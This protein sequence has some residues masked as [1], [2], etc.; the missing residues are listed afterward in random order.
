M[1]DEQP[2]LRSLNQIAS[3]NPGRFDVIVV[4]YNHHEYR[5]RCSGRPITIYG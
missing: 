5:L 1:L 2:S 3:G 4:F